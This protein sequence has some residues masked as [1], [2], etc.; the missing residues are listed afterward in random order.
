MQPVRELEILGSA[1]QAQLWA[2]T[3][4]DALID[5]MKDPTGYVREHFADH[6]LRRADRIFLTILLDGSI[7]TENLI[8]V[9]TVDGKPVVRAEGARKK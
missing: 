6:G 9:D 7:Y 8:C 5:V 2:L 1:R 4:T 3:T